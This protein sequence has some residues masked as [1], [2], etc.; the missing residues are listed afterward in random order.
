[1]MKSH[2]NLVWGHSALA[3][4]CTSQRENAGIEAVEEEV[5]EVGDGGEDDLKVD[6]RRVRGKILR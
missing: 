2:Q 4:A 1:M 3:R 6:L 5:E